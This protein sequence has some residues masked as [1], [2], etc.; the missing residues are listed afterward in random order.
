MS[1]RKGG[2]GTRE[3]GTT[4]TLPRNQPTNQTTNRQISA[5]HQPRGADRNWQ[6]GYHSQ[7]Y[8]LTDEAIRGA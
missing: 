8:K 6:P 7:L 2:R 3:Q 1:K 4:S 5:Q